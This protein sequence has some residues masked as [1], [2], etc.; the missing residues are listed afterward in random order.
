MKTLII[1]P[2]AEQRG[3]AELALTHLIEARSPS[4]E[5]SVAFL[6]NGPMVEQYRARGIDVHVVEA[7]QLRDIG[8]FWATVER[9]ASIARREQV[10]ALLSW[11]GKPHLYGAIAGRVTG[12]P[13][14]W[15][16]HGLPS[17]KN[18]LDRLTAMLSTQGILA[19]SGTVAKAQ[20]LMGSTCPIEVAYPGV[21][22]GR[23]DAALLTSPMETR[24][25]LGLPETG[26]LIGM[27]GR[28]Q[29]WKGMHVLIEAMPAILEKHAE[30]HCVI[31]GGEHRLEA[32]YPTFLRGRIEALGLGDKIHLA[33]L[34]RN[35]PEWMQ[36]MDVIVHA[37]DR[38]PFG[39]VVIEAMALGKPVVAGD[40]GG[41]TEI[42]TD[43]V[44]GLLTPYGDSPKLVD[45]VL[46]YLDD[47]EIARSI[48]AVARRRAEDFSTQRYASTVEQSVRS[49]VAK[50]K[51]RGATVNVTHA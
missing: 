1:M 13:A 51:R 26:P 43:G 17:T 2:C 40:A 44:D 21:E 29:R 37:S 27:V 22:L 9:L 11:M 5:W 19:C 47:P 4:M 6:E 10:D 25:R 39:M 28:L 20:R 50:S 48:G 35:V 38:E 14:L 32:D 36:A 8:R 49:L 46:K 12:I 30:A 18:F 41:P 24:K 42:I 23:Y 33:G 45:A 31:V 3:G 7:G 34:Q 16:Q 15:Y